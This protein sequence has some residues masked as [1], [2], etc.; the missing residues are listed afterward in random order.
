MVY[1][2]WMMLRLLVMCMVWHLMLFTPDGVHHV[3]EE[4]KLIKSN[5]KIMQLM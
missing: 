1:V 2:D 3:F 4:E 5:E